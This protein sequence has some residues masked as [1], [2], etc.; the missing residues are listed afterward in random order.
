VYARPELPPLEFR[1][2]DGSVIPYGHRWGFDGPPADA[3]SRTEHPQRFA[4][5]HD[6]ALALMADLRVVPAA[7][8]P[9]FGPHGPSASLRFDPPNDGASPIVVALTDFPGVRL[10]AG[11]FFSAAFPACG[12]DACDEG[13]EETVAQL[14]KTVFAIRAGRLR[15]SVSGGWITQSIVLDNGSSSG[16]SRVEDALPALLGHDGRALVPRQWKAWA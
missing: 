16:S 12:C 1:D 2:A 3:Y 11:A 9:L 15:E 13:L 4:P 7:G 8:G 5:L 14:E 6:V 10:R